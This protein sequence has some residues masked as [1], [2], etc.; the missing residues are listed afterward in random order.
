MHDAEWLQLCV[1]QFMGPGVALTC[2][3]AA[4]AIVLTGRRAPITLLALATVGGVY[5]WQVATKYSHDF[6]HAVFDSCHGYGSTLHASYVVAGIGIFA[7]IVG[8]LKRRRSVEL[9]RGTRATDAS[10]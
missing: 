2:G 3:G 1:E 9:E 7:T 10:S 6:S 8:E 5:G 4:L